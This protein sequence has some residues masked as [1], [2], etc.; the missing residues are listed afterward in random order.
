MH[1][2]SVLRSDDSGRVSV[3]VVAVMAVVIVLVWRFCCSESCAYA[4]LTSIV[5]RILHIY[6]N[7]IIVYF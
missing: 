6:Q 2:R 3:A 5:K 4:G 7:L 1:G